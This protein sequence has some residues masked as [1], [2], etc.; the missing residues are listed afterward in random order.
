MRA[1][2]DQTHAYQYTK[3]EHWFYYNNLHG[4]FRLNINGVT[5][6]KI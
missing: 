2:I 4:A 5:L 3:L 1:F 6:I